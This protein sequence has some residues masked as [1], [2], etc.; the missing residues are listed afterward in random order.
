MPDI[1]INNLP[2]YITHGSAT[3]VFAD[4]SILYKEIKSIKESQ[5]LQRDINNLQRWESDWF[6]EFHPQKC[7]VLHITDKRKIIIYPYNIHGHILDSVKNAKYLG[8]HIHKQLNWNTHVKKIIN[9]ANSTCSFLQRNMRQ[10]REHIK[11][12]AYKAM[13]SS[14]RDQ[15]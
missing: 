12:L 8:I 13:V 11:E 14:S 3:N 15:F 5:D 2:D 9:K 7:Q 10:S 1:N 4:G 6:I